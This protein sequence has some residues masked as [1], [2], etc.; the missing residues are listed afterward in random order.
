MTSPSPFQTE[1][2]CEHII[3]YSALVRL[4]LEYHVLFWASRSIKALMNESESSKGHQ[5][6]QEAGP[7]GLTT[8]MEHMLDGSNCMKEV[9]L[10]RY[11]KRTITGDPAASFNWMR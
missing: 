6:S 11:K 10:F 7:W 2:P 8:G 4:H 1:L 5:H 9:G 3:L